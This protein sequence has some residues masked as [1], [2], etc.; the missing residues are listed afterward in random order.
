MR[1]HVT[2]FSVVEL[3]RHA[4]NF[5]EMCFD[6]Q[7]TTIVFTI[8]IVSAWVVVRRFLKKA[9]SPCRACTHLSLVLLKE[10]GAAHE[11]IAG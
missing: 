10:R 3:T 11:G 5:I 8:V 2:L 1:A 6:S 7:L 9:H 4:N